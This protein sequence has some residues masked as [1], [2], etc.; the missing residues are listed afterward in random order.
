[1]KKIPMKKVNCD[2][3]YHEELKTFCGEKDI[4]LKGFLQ[5]CIDLHIFGNKE[6]QTKT[7]GLNFSRIRTDYPTVK[8]KKGQIQKNL[9]EF[10]LYLDM[11]KPGDYTFAKL[12]SREFFPNELKGHSSSVLYPY[13]KWMY[14]AYIAEP[15]EE[16]VSFPIFGITIKGNFEKALQEAE[17]MRAKNE[18]RIEEGKS[19][20]MGIDV[21]L[22]SVCKFHKITV[23][24]LIARIR[25]HLGYLP[26]LGLE[27]YQKEFIKRKKK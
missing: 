2:E 3:D 25:E 16:G 6:Y 10:V 24:E 21:I 5:G 12:S 17:I 20:K 13:I 19:T 9:A 22:S 27:E 4:S 14:Y 26:H 18:T 7:G 1:M 15:I 23:L 11:E 8:V